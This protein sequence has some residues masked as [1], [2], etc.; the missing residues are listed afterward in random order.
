MK[1]SQPDIFILDVDGVM[2]T[3]QFVYSDQGKLL[4][5][6]GAHDN[7]GIKMIQKHV[8]I[9][10]ITA[11]KRGFGIT[12]KRIVEDMG[13][14]LMLVKEYERMEFIEKTYGLANIA[15]MGDGYHDAQILKACFYGIAPGNARIE[16]I[17]S[18][19]FVT[20]SKSG[21]GAVLDACLHLIERFFYRAL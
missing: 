13:Q 14:Q 7:D 17:R 6:F 9:L 5:V 15:Y 3:G 10:F 4:K 16:A 12:K 19:N 18:A 21:E 2:T 1:K 8:A 11:D 20:P